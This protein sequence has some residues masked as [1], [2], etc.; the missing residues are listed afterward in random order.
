MT[1][2]YKLADVERSHAWL[3]NQARQWRDINGDNP[4]K[5]VQEVAAIVE[6]LEYSRGLLGEVIATFSILRNRE[7]IES[8]GEPGERLL[9]ITDEWRLRYLRIFE[10][11]PDNG[12]AIED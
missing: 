5:L 7:V 6:A 1:A 11:V 3:E 10:S 2:N 4:S 9:R 8:F 12:S